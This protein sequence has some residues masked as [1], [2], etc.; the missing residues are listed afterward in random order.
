M[1]CG[2]VW[3]ICYFFL[4]AWAFKTHT[5]FVVDETTGTAAIFI[6]IWVLHAAQQSQV[7]AL[8]QHFYE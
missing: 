8:P 2:V 7:K 1:L 3:Y 5:T 6:L 4:N